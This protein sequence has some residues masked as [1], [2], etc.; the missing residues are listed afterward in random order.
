M[1]LNA[2]D[3]NEIKAEKDGTVGLKGKAQAHRS[4]MQKQGSKARLEG[5]GAP[6]KLKEDQQRPEEHAPLAVLID[7]LV[8][9]DA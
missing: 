1:L 2:F 7:G 3:N 6:R 5:Q 4:M 9:A 8:N